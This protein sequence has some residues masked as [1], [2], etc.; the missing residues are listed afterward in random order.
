MSQLRCVLFDLDGTLVDT[1]PDLGAAANHVLERKGLPTLPLDVYRPV[2]SGGA[3][4]LLGRALG[5]TQDNP[6]FPALRDQ[7]LEYYRAH[8]S[9]R[10]C[11]FDGVHALLSALAER[12]IAWGV[13]TNKPAW[14]TA[15]L[16]QALPWPTAPACT[17]SADEAVRAKPDPA[18]LHLACERM[19][20]P[21]KSCLYV[22]DDLRD[23]QAGQAAGMRSIAAAWGYIDGGSP[24]QS[25][26]ADGIADTPN[27]VLDW[28]HPAD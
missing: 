25:W 2:S 19:S 18:P 14:L 27:A 9:E 7:F 16:M 8:L 17:V 28:L 21:A 24:I 5:I 11:A 10:S 23:I 26:R 15:P 20:I 13:V 3:R 22:G 1:A 6:E 4:G 12:G